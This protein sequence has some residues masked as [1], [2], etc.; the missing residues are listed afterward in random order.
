MAELKPVVVAPPDEDGVPVTPA[1]PIRP[2]PVACVAYVSTHKGV[3]HDMWRVDYQLPGGRTQPHAF[4]AE[5]PAARCAQLG[6]T[7]D[8][9][10]RVLELLLHEPW[11]P[12]HDVDECYEM[13]P[14]QFLA[15]HTARYRAARKIVQLDSR[16]AVLAPLRAGHRITP[17]IVAAH[18]A[19]IEEQRVIVAARASEAPPRLSVLGLP[20]AATA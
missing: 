14:A 12:E 11:M 20:L 3:D 2:T 5:L 17:E 6:L 16:H 8:D 18:R 4:P 13:T 9:A 15:A 1:E 19:A 10:G 7:P